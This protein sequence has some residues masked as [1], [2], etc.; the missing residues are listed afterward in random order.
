M[1][2]LGAL[3]GFVLGFVAGQLLLL[4]LFAGG[5]HLI[6]AQKPQLKVWAGLL[7][8]ILAFFG[9][10][11]GY[12]DAGQT[13][14]R[15]DMVASLMLIAAMLASLADPI[16]LAG[17]V[18]SGALIRNYWAAVS[19]GVFWR[20]LLHVVLVIPAANASQSTVPISILVT[21][22]VGAFLVTSVVFL[23]AKKTRKKLSSE[24]RSNEA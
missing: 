19:T 17:Y 6:V 13:L 1:G 18:A 8:L 4:L 7:V 16:S 12:Q 11:I 22:S 24:R 21:A 5:R 15:G 3:A 14:P 10:Y 20:V 23:M 9:G 2:I